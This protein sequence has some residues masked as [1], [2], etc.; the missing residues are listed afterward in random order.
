MILDTWNGSIYERSTIIEKLRIL[1]VD[2]II[3]WYFVKPRPNVTEWFWNKPEIIDSD[4]KN[5]CYQ[6]IL[7]R[8]RYKAFHKDA[9]RV[10]TDGFDAVIRINPLMCA[11]EQVLSTMQTS[12]T[13]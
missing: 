8:Y 6:R 10:D 3:A 12:L 1:R 2:I 11:P 4:F 13:L 5:I 9:R 7:Q